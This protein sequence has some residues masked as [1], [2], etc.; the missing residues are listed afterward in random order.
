MDALRAKSTGEKH[1]FL[2]AL[3]AKSTDEKHGFF[4]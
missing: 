4:C 3:T 1:G 2:N